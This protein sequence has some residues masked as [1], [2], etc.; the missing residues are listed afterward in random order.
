MHNI[1]ID[2]KPDQLREMATY[3][4]VEGII[5]FGKPA[6]WL[7]AKYADTEVSV[8]VKKKGK[9]LLSEEEAK[10]KLVKELMS[11]LTS[12]SRSWRF[13]FKDWIEDMI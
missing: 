9:V 7:Y 8:V 11:A 4:Y 2:L 12:R 10:D 6:T 3:T 13:I 1:E 5:P